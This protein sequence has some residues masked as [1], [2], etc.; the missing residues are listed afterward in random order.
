MHMITDAAKGAVGA[1]LQMLERRAAA[2]REMR[3]SGRDVEFIR[4]QL[5]TVE[6]AMRYFAPE[7]RHAERLPATGP[8][9]VVGNH[10]GLFYMPDMWITA[11]ALVHRRG[12]DAPAF[13]LGYDLLFAIPGVESVIRRF[14]ALPASGQAAEQA[15]AEDAAVLVYPGGDWEACRPWT[16]RNRVDLHGRTGFVRLA[17]R[18]GAAVVPV[19]A[20]GAHHSV[21]VLTRGEGIARTLGLDRLRVKVMPFLVGVPFGVAPVVLPPLPL[22]TKVTVDFLDAHDWSSDGPAAADDPRLVQ[23]RYDEVA[24]ALQAGLDTL[25]AERP[26]PL[27]SR[28]GLAR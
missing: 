20:H 7:V 2:A 18:T 14:G 16:Q 15:L 26:H 6:A 9:L 10:S 3:S 17:L 5:P 22:P 4:R 11:A 21:M 25:A 8:V 13:G 19:V 23:E 28:F 24:E 1:P 27:L 12:L